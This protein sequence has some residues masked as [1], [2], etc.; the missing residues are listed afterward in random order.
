MNGLEVIGGIVIS[1]L[2]YF[3]ITGLGAVIMTLDDD[4]YELGIFTGYIIGLFL[5]V[6]VF[7]L[8]MSGEPF[9]VSLN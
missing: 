3:I 9:P 8:W 1:G 7:M 5:F 4:D 2:L 6:I